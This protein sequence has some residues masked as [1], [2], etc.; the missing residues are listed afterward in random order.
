[1]RLTPCAR[2]RAR[3]VAAACIQ[4]ADNF[5][6]KYGLAGDA[7]TSRIFRRRFAVHYQ[8]EWA[9]AFALD[10]ANAVLTDNTW[11][12]P[13]ALRD[14]PEPTA[15]S[16]APLEFSFGPKDKQRIMQPIHIL[17]CVVE[18]AGADNKAA[19]TSE[20]NQL[21]LRGVSGDS[22]LG[23][24]LCDVAATRTEEDGTVIRAPFMDRLAWWKN[25]AAK[26][27]FPLLAQ[28]AAKLLC[29]HTTSCASERNWSL[30]GNVYTKSRSNLA[31]RRAMKLI[32]IRHNSGARGA[33]D[34]DDAD[35][36]LALL[37]GCD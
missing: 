31:L 17:S 18:L 37:E 16:G 28:A 12:F 20:L 1:L 21:K 29:C 3:C 8:K 36:V 26:E 14:L 13:L 30:W 5:D 19:V 11:T 24:M 27:G 34:T 4:H 10:P 25:H 7:R 23:S 9:A 32:S 15:P 6:A 2:A 35:V 22:E 33:Y